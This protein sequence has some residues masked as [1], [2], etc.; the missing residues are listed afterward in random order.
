M[1]ESAEVVRA[2]YH[3]VPIDN[4]LGLLETLRDD[5]L[6]LAACDRHEDTAAD[7]VF[8]APEGVYYNPEARV[9]AYCGQHLIEGDGDNLDAILDQTGGYWTERGDYRPILNREGL[10]DFEEALKGTFVTEDVPPAPESEVQ[11]VSA[12]PA[13]LVRRLISRLHP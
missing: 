6:A 9:V 8:A 11:T 1:T 12:D 2:Q 13:G 7:I 5:P 10:E 3:V 4:T